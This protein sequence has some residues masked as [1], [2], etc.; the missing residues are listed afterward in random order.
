MIWTQ[1]TDSF[2]YDDNSAR[3]EHASKRLIVLFYNHYVMQSTL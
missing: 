3:L 2:S 1:F